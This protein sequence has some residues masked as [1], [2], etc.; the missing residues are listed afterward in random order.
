MQNKK[1][2]FYLLVTCG[3]PGS[4]KTTFSRKFAKDKKFV[5]L[6]SHIIRKQL[7]LERAKGPERRL[8]TEMNKQAL[9]FLKK[10]KSV[11][12]DST[13]ATEDFRNSLKNLAQRHKTNFLILWFKATLGESKQ[14]V[15]KRN[16][17]LDKFS[18]FVDEATIK[19]VKKIFENPRKNQETVILNN[20]MNYQE[21]K[22]LVNAALNR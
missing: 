6:N 5:H 3:L 4:G 22:R 19:E 17:S 14:S 2:K 18:G 21:Q 9:A 8:F 15:K 20:K 7:K 12:Y 11:I 16:N 1:D 13:G 10:G